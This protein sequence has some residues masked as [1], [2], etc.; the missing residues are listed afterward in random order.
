MRGVKVLTALLAAGALSLSATIAL[1]AASPAPEGTKAPGA[2]KTM[3]TSKAR[4]GKET[5]ADRT[6]RGEVTAIEPSATPATLSVKLVRGKETKSLDVIVPATAKITQGKTV[7]T[8]ADIKVGDRV[9]VKYDQMK[10]HKEADQIRI[11]KSASQMTKPKT[12]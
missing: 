2:S 7:K 6:L 8:L 11:L 5:T 9:W 1:A 10:D 4:E 12:S 3:T